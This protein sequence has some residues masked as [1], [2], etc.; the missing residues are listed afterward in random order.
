MKISDD[1]LRILIGKKA[2]NIKET[3]PQ[4]Q[5]V[6]GRVVI[7]FILFFLFFI[8]VHSTGRQ[9]ALKPLESHTSYQQ[10]HKKSPEL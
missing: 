2:R 10:Q 3:R 8:F 9:F 4:K 7:L 5:S 6:H 1:L